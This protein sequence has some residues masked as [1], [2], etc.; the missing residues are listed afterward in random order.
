M[1][2]QFIITALGFSL[3]HYLSLHVLEGFIFLI[4]HVPPAAMNLDS[5]IVALAWF[6]KV[7]VGPRLLLRH[8]WF[9]ETT[10]GWLTVSLTIVNSLVWGYALAAGYRWWRHR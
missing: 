4:A 7:L 2:R 3:A 10:P 6:G 5:V 9:S 8:L 1:T